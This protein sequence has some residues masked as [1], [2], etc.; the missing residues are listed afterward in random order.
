MGRNEL[1]F[2]VGV[3]SPPLNLQAGRLPTAGCPQ[4]LIFLFSIFAATTISRG[5]LLCPQPEDAPCRGDRGPLN[6]D[7]LKTKE[8]VLVVLLVC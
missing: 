6:V 8:K 5:H 7:V 2:S 1:L 3:V 4:L